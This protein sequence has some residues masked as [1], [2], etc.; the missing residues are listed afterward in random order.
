[1]R[2]LLA[3]ARWLGFDAQ[4]LGVSEFAELVVE[5]RR[6]YWVGRNIMRRRD[7]LVTVGCVGIFPCIGVSASAA[8]SDP[9]ILLLRR[10]TDDTQRLEIRGRVT[11]AAGKPLPGVRVHFRHA[12]PNGGYTGQY[13][14]T[15]ISGAMGEYKLR[16]TR[17]GAY[18]PPA[19]IHIQAQH[20]SAGA[21][22]TQIFF[23]GD[24]RLR[25]DQEQHAIALETIRIGDTQAFVGVFDIKFSN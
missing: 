3:R 4:I 22:Y 25:S 7:L 15:A 14:G 5:F 16:T 20:K 2:L 17:P 10:D 11:D 8:D 19:H 6:S 23:K 1:M 21:I 24:P 18:G 12:A 9:S 13:E